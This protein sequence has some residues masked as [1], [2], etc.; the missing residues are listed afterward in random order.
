M[1][2]LLR[3]VNGH[4]WQADPGGSAPCPLCGAPEQPLGL[5][6]TFPGSRPAFTINP[7]A[8]QAPPVLA[9][10]EVLEE[11]GRGGMGIVYR[12]RHRDSGQVVALKVIRKE[13]LG[14]ADLVSRFRR[15]AQASSRLQHPNLVQ[16]FEADLA[17]QTPFLAIEFVP[18]LTLQKL[19]EDAGPLPVALACDF[20]RQVALG[21]EHADRMRLVHRDIKPSNIMVLAPAGLPLPP[22]PL[23]KILDMGVARLFQAENDVPL[24]TLT[25][26]GSVIGT[27]DYIAPEQLENPRGVDIRADIYS[28]GCTLYFLL[29]GQVP[30]PGGSLVQKLD[31]QRWHVAPAV[32]QLRPDIAPAVAAVVRKLMAKHPDD[33]Y[34]NAGELASALEALARTGVLPGI[35]ALASLPA[36]KAL[37]GHKGGVLALAWAGG[38]L[39][40]AGSDRTIRLW[41]AS[42][43]QEV[44][45]C[46]E[47]KLEVSALAGLPGLVLACHGVTMRAYDL[48]TG[49]EALRLA[50]HTDSL[51]CV[52]A[53]ADGKLA[54]TGGDDRTVRVW[55][56]ERG[57]L[58][59]RFA[60]HSAS[61]SGVALLARWPRHRLGGAR[62]HGAGLGRGDGQ[63]DQEHRRA[64]G[65]DHL[66]RLGGRWQGDL[67]GAL[68][69]DVASVGCP[70]PGVAALRRAQADGDG[71]GGAGPAADVVE[72][73]PDGPALGRG[74]RRRGGGVPGPHRPGVGGGGGA[75]WDVRHG[76]R[77]WNGTAVA[78]AVSQNASRAERRMPPPRKSM[79][80]ASSND[81][82]GQ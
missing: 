82:Q 23:V 4:E 67:H 48:A 75:G 54:A 21:L 74:R 79:P 39:A 37:A 22:R 11:I 80:H 76:R 57:S 52:A 60:K 72:Q 26:D 55:D 45:R 24:T 27:P 68:R 49:K 62:R 59:S 32:G 53:S 38:L 40:S 33:R 78:D 18:G 9:G 1:T 30:F 8:P 35:A 81:S 41:D 16:V 10:Y 71:P 20:I 14:S 44:R 50:G 12:A 7:D 66:H 34:Q 63:G 56:L 19:V 46:G 61:V 51:R 15:E 58:L 70:G 5:P 64:E 6:P 69:H 36:Q 25:R 28:L 31:R 77:R 47:G 42:A 73:G 43:G 3:C 13:K 17:G 2:T 65:A 29:T